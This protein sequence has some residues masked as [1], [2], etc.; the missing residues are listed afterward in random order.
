MLY[1]ILIYGSESAVAA[2]EPGVEEDMLER[3]AD[4]RDDLQAQGRLGMVLRL[5]PDVATTVRRA[6]DLHPLVTDGP[7]AETKEQ[8]MGIYIVECETL[9]DATHAAHRLA[10]ETGVFEIR[11]VT[12]YDPGTIAAR[13]PQV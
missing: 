5:M 6:G 10:F 2:W 8:L 7:F 9:D 13:I 3:H 12:W 4:L 11:P 1:S